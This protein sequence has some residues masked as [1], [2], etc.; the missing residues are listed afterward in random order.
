MQMV[1]KYLLIGSEC[2]FIRYEYEAKHFFFSNESEVDHF[3]YLKIVQLS[4]CCFTF[5]FTSVGNR[6]YLSQ[7]KIQKQKGDLEIYFLQH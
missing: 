4:F 6:K 1:G 2:L 3:S 7:N 5:F